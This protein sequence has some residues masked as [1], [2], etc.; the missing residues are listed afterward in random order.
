MTEQTV[1]FGLFDWIDFSA[2][3]KLQSLY[4]QR[5]RMLQYADEAGFYCYHLAEHHLTH[6][7]GVP[8]PGVFL[9]AASQRTR[10]IRL[11]AL[12]FL[13]PLYH[14]VRLAQEICML[15]HLSG[16][17]L[18]VGTGRGISPH[19]LRLLG[20]DAEDSRAQH[21]EAFE[22]LLELLATGELSGFHGKHYDYE[23]LDIVLRT[24]QKPYPP[25]WYPVIDPDRARWAA[26]EGI[27]TVTLLGADENT[28]G[29]VQTYAEAWEANKASPHRLNAHVK[30][31]K[32]GLMRQVYIA[33]SHEEA[34]REAKA[35]HALHTEA[36]LYLWS[37]FGEAHEHAYL[38]DWD[39]QLASGGLMV[40]TPSEIQEQVE[41]QLTVTGANYFV[42]NF[43]FG[44]LTDEQVMRSTEAFA[45][46]VMPKVGATS[47]T[48]APA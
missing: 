42:C 1:Q 18:D 22:I 31:P 23:P 40:G 35:A 11:G 14:P 7:S 2:P 3:E 37:V 36:F 10:R 44:D 39:G 47:A 25:L 34:M 27:N 26:N 4:E 9:A 6:L 32:F 20:A 19:E 45:T 8:S 28:R 29:L 33:E 15:D 12:V 30:Q 41:Q 17:R 13:L 38:K 48:F 21:N 46:E 24:V 5:L 16:G 43:A